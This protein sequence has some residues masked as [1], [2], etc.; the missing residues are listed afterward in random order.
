MYA[1][2]N[3]LFCL[4]LY[5]LIQNKSKV[6]LNSELNYKQNWLLSTWKNQGFYTFNFYVSSL[7]S[8]ILFKD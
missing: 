8:D 2:Y 4:Y 6:V 7:D 3:L 1:N 5:F